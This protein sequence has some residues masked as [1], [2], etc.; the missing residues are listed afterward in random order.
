MN[1][2]LRARLLI[3][4]TLVGLL[5]LVVLAVFLAGVARLEAQLVFFA[6]L[7]VGAVLLVGL[8]GVLWIGARHA[9]RLGE[10]ETAAGRV[11]AGD[12]RARALEQPS[13]EVGRLGRAFNDMAAELH[14]RLGALER[15][16][17]ERERIL[18]HMSDG[19]ALIDHDGRFVH[20]NQRFAELQGSPLPPAGLT[21]VTE[22]VRV[23]E[24]HELLRSARELGQTVEIEA[25]LWSPHRGLLR[26]TATPIGPRA[27]EAILLVLHD[28]TE[29]EQLNRI[30]QDF[31]ANVSHELRTPLTSLRGYAE[32]LLDGGL[33]DEVH[34]EGFVRTIRDQAAR[35]SA[36][37]EDLLS[38]SELERPG[39]SLKADAFDLRSTI[40]DQVKTLQPRARTIGLELALEPGA[41]VPVVA[42][43]VRIEQVIANLLDNALKY[44]E[45]GRV[46]VRLGREGS[47]IW[48]EVEDTG[49]G[50]PAADQP[51]VFERFY[52][53]DR[54][55]SR[56]K[57]G[58]GLGLSIVKH[59]VALHGGT[60][61]VKSRPDDG[62]TFR[63]EIPASPPSGGGP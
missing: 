31:V 7:A 43:R 18:A 15:E 28:L 35:L 22:Y 49:P 63:F 44:T 27:R 2:S 50:I 33:E 16:R 23:P 14:A 5:A 48:C 59:V 9:R 3:G 11:G 58:T 20:A 47:A 36:L 29:V 17:D 45:E 30:R 62:S 39:A 56:E 55:R 1:L 6:A 40:E 60:I 21:P 26:A 19:V 54:T 53:V 13:D 51:R 24:L 42:D 12:R 8:A 4:F 37:V 57:G 46:H 34:R 32:T 52:R 38:L 41:P 61:S 25:R 10:I